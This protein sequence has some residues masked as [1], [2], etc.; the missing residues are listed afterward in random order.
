MK[1]KFENG[2]LWI[3]QKFWH[4]R[5]Y[6]KLNLRAVINVN[7]CKIT[8]IIKIF[9]GDAAVKGLKIVELIFILIINV[10]KYKLK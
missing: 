9:E 2:I 5:G 7:K 1:I 10:N 4:C 3:K 8:I 6:I